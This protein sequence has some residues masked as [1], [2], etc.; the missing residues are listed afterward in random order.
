MIF[1]DSL[2]NK[3]FRLFVQR[4]VTQLKLN[5]NLSSA[6]QQLALLLK[7]HPKIGF[8]MENGHID[9]QEEFPDEEYNPFI[10]LAALWEVEKQLLT[11]SP[12]G[13]KDIFESSQRQRITKTETLSKLSVMYLDFFN[14]NK[15]GE[16]IGDIAYVAE[17]LKIVQNP[18]YFE[19]KFLTDVV[20]TPQV[21]DEYSINYYNSALD[22]A[23]SHF[24]AK[25]HKEVGDVNTKPSNKLTGCLNKLPSEW[26]NATAIFWN[27][28]A[29]KLKRDRIADLSSF[30]L[31]PDNWDIILAKLQQDELALL[32][33][34]L[35][36][37]GFL[38]YGQLTKRF[39][40][41]DMV[42]WWTQNPPKSAIGRVRYKG[43]LFIGVA[44]FNA[45]NYK[46]GLIPKDLLAILINKL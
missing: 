2:D 36:K 5:N 6:E 23:F 16:E 45:R 25:M 3:T 40:T 10:L 31:S 15:S 1:P 44:P 20:D 37:N 17:A 33:F 43:F 46:I 7:E 19:N 26:V 27:R 8:N 34:L 22:K 9:I 14:R 13:I 4:T 29:Q 35:G 28:P 41:E 21:K 39:G 38:K 32:S 18:L 42:Y 12:K 30:L 11:N 24:Q